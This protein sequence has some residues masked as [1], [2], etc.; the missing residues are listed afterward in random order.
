MIDAYKHAE[1]QEYLLY[2]L[3]TKQKYHDEEEG[4]DESSDQE[5]LNDS[6]FNLKTLN[7]NELKEPGAK[8]NTEAAR[9]ILPGGD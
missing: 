3:T 8:R 5:S 1:A 4:D 9:E 6:S 7:M 2:G